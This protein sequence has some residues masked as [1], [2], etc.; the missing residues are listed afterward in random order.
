MSSAVPLLRGIVQLPQRLVTAF[1]LLSRELTEQSARRRTYILRVIYAVAVYGFTV[2]IFWN[3]LGGWSK[4]TFS[5]LGRGR[6]FFEALAWLQFC[7]LYLFLPPMTCGV[8]TIEKERDTLS[9]LLLTRLGPWSILIGKLLSR[10]VPMASFV[11]LSL[12]LVAVAYSLGGVNEREILSLAWVLTVTALQIGS[13]ALAC[14]TWF[15]TTSAAFMATYLIG[16]ALIIGPPTLFQQGTDDPFG[17]REFL[18][19]YLQTMGLSGDKTLEP[20]EAMLVLFGPWVNLHPTGMN[21]P[22]GVIVLRTIP[23]LM[24]AAAC[25]LFARA[26][27]WRR[28]FLQPS[29]LIMKIFRSLDASFHRLNQNRWTKGIVLVNEQVELPYYDPIRWRETKK[30]SLGTT[31]YLVRLLL[32]LE[33]PVVFGMLIPYF[34]EYDS[35]TAPVNIAA[36]VLWIVSALVLVIQSTGL[37]GAER[38]RQTL[39]VMLTTPMSSDTIAREKFAGIWRLIRVLWIPFAT[40]YLFQLWWS[41]WAVS[42]GFEVVVFGLV[43]GLL[44]T[45]IYPPLIA[46]LG[47]HLGMR[48]RSQTQATI[49]ALSLITGV[50]LI[51]MLMSEFLATRDLPVFR[52]FQWLSP[53]AALSR[54]PSNDYNYYGYW[55][56]GSFYESSQM[57]WFGVMG[58]FVLAG[59]LLLWLWARALKTFAHHVQRNDGQ[60]VDDDDIERLARLREKIVGSGVFRPRTDEE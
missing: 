47:F 46:W 52:A 10:L 44:A 16:G 58:H 3:E 2:W 9:L 45:A 18:R 24:F 38:S 57:I 50:C 54:F 20:Q 17:M 59:L 39:D 33:V 23:M 30:R 4:Q 11:L 14:S 12:P 25:L 1:P 56:Y 49:L 60:V 51:P 41:V 7:G 29:N 37:I 28:A 42:R 34:G 15:R 35:P 26:V 6:Q 31:R 43:R 55:N 5:Y 32:V 8:V 53:A 22:F 40:V 27:L 13:L 48:C 19:E 21:Q 36:Y